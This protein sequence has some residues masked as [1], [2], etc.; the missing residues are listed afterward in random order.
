VTGP[1]VSGSRTSRGPAPGHV[2]AAGFT[3]IGVS[4]G[5]ARYGYGLFLPSIRT[6]FALSTGT[7]GLI[8]SGGYAA[9]LLALVATGLF[10][11]RVGPR[12]LVVTGCLAAAVGMAMIG[13]APHPAL[14]A[15]GVW[16]A[17]TAPGWCWSPFSDAIARLVP[18]DLQHR[19]LSVITT[20][21][22][23][24]ILISAPV[25]WMTTAEPAEWRHA[26]LVFAALAL[27]AALW[28]GLL[29]PSGP[30]QADEPEKAGAERSS[31][32]TWFT[33]PGSAALF[34][35]SGGFGFT[36]TVYWTYAVDRIARSQGLPTVAKTTFWILLGTFGIAGT[37]TGRLVTRF[38]LRTMLLANLV[39]L[40]AA[41][42]LLVAPPQWATITVSATLFGTSFMVI[43]A[44]LVIWS[45]DVFSE[46][47]STG[48]SAALVFLALGT[49]A[50]PAVMGIL[51]D[52]VGLGTILGVTAA[53]TVP[54]ALFRPKHDVQASG[55]DDDQ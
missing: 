27:G 40:A 34:A 50:G 49:I 29:L 41:P 48:F 2:A 9:Y 19:T 4:F 46:Q 30:H 45:A 22:T 6:E 14:L 44:L 39:A 18:P 10:V 36:S 26:W 1:F 28:N 53:L 3:A 31:S 47:P 37:A 17:A 21:T 33:R 7:L 52:H 12:L 54:V 8:A 43:S 15:A 35:A 5:F 20:G 51:A 25:M 32:L 11:S 13:L 38:G 23:F 16:I 24:G 42:A 55:I